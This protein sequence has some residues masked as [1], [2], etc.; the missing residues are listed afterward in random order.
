MLQIRKRSVLLNTTN[1]LRSDLYD[2]SLINRHGF[3]E[4]EE[5]ENVYVYPHEKLNI[6][7]SALPTT[8]DSSFIGTLYIDGKYIDT[9]DSLNDFVSY[10]FEICLPYYTKKFQ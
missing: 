3:L 9:F 7:F 2:S 1:M 4:S 8:D 6:Q 10:F 5:F